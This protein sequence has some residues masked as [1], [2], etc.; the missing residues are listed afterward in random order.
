MST[1]K[2]KKPI[3]RKNASNTRGRPFK[4]GNPGRPM[5]ATIKRMGR[6]GDFTVH[7]FRSAFRDWAAEQTN[8]PRD[9]AEAALAH[10]I[11]DAVERAYRRGD[12]FEKRYKLME[13]WA[14]YCSVI[15]KSGEIIPIRLR[16]HDGTLY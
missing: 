9:V 1:E 11:P 4:K 5:L 16:T 10:T 2:M 8:Y 3:T 14:Q 12:L 15:T 6:S 7:G 13:E